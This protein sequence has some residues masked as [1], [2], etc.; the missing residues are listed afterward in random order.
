MAKSI[1]YGIRTPKS[2]F[3]KRANDRNAPGKV[4]Y[5]KTAPTGKQAP[6]TQNKGIGKA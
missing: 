3:E 5:K 2:D 1:E 4:V 6:A